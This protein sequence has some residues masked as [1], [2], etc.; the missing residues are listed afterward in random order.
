[1]IAP[2]DGRASTWAFVSGILVPL[3]VIAVSQAAFFR[4]VPSCY[5]AVA[6]VATLIACIAYWRNTG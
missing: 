3:T 1:M 5:A 4:T 2:V 6:T